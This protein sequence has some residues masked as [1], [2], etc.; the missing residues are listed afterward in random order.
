VALQY[1]HSGQQ[2]SLLLLDGFGI[3]DK[4]WTQTF[5]DGSLY[6]YQ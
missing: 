3:L 5:S 6:W 2:L 1:K 4:T